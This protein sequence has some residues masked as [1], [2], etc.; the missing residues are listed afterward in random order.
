MISLTRKWL[1]SQKQNFAA[2]VHICDAPIRNAGVVEV[3][4]VV[5]DLDTLLEVCYWPVGG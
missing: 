3:K 5:I 1:V 4:G 2:D